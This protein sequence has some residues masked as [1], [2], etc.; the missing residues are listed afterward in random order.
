[1]INQ[2]VNPLGVDYQIAMLQGDLYSSLT[3]N[4]G[5]T[6]Y[7]S[8]DR[9]YKNER[10]KEIVP[11]FYL[12]NRDYKEVLFDDKKN[13]TSFF[14][15]DD[16]RTYSKENLNFKQG[17]S[18]IVQAKLD[19]LLPLITHRADEELISQVINSANETGWGASFTDVI[20]GIDKVY[21]DLKINRT[22]KNMDDMSNYFICRFDF[23]LT[24]EMNKCNFSI[25]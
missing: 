16:Q 21:S 15:A 18:F 1:M 3:M 8:Y 20:T 7:E 17:V 6:N 4:Y 25:C 24:Y 12:S 10:A 23:E 5:W 9:A 14:L 19:K 2:R 13:V 11:E 22:K